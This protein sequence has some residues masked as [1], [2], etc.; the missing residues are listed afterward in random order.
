MDKKPALSPQRQEGRQQERMLPH[1]RPASC[2]VG[3]RLLAPSARRTH[4][5][6]GPGPSPVLPSVSGYLTGQSVSQCLVV[7]LIIYSRYY[8]SSPRQ[9]S[10]AHSPVQT[11]SGQ[12]L[13]TRRLAA[14]RHTANRSKEREGRGEKEI[15]KKERGTPACFV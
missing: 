14:K 8:K 11:C 5:Q 10:T 7:I 2:L 13:Q 12:T 6:P 4:H 15:S 9:V 3:N 1:H